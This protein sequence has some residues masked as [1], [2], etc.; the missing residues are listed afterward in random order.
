MRKRFTIISLVGLLLLAAIPGVALAA[1]PSP[2]SAGGV[3]VVTGISDPVPAG[4]SGRVRI[5]SEDLATPFGIE[6][7]ATELNGA[8]MVLNQH[9]NELF[10]GV[11]VNLDGSFDL[12]NAVAVDGN[13]AGTFAIVR[14]GDVIG[15]GAYNLRVSNNPFCQ[16]YDDGRWSSTGTGVQ[17][18]GTV[19]ACLNWNDDLGT[20]VGGITIS[21]SLR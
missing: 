21:G 15:T 8:A 12:S 20:F 5:Q 19:F 7:A 2:F 13:S 3:V 1:K 11:V 9:S 18:Q 17:G 4:F 10:D 6:S 14:D 16:I